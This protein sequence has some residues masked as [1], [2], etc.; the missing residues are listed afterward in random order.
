MESGNRVD[1]LEAVRWVKCGVSQR[2]VSVELSIDRK[3]IGNWVRDEEKL[4][5]MKNK[6]LKKRIK[7]GGKKP[8]YPEIEEKLLNYFM[9]K[10]EK[11]HSVT[12]PMLRAFIMSPTSGISLPEEFKISDKYLFGWTRRNNLVSR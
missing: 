5:K 12:Y 10:R 6:R 1:K 8:F 4:L 9:A 11:N 2:A 3:Q 7:G